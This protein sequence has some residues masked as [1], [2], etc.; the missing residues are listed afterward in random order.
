MDRP[1][2]PSS[3]HATGGSAFHR[4]PRTIHGIARPAVLLPEGEE[5]DDA[6][7]GDAN[8][9][10]G[11]QPD[12]GFPA[13]TPVAEMT[14]EQQVAYWRHYARQHEERANARGDYDAVKAKAAELDKIREQQMSEQEKAVKA[15]R[16]AALAE[17]RTG[18]LRD[19]NTSAV[20]AILDAS[21]QA[22][23]RTP[24][25][26]AAMLA[27]TNFESFVT[28]GAP[29]TGAILGHVDSIAGPVTGGG[30]NGTGTP[31][32]GQGNRGPHGKATGIEAGAAMYRERHG[33]K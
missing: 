29:D 12:R 15:A 7:T 14:T 11:G 18:A 33:T 28:D 16:E 8:G 25:Q 5:H 19:A 31:D 13:G 21:L 32:H 17:G 10:S 26:V 30:G 1:T 2:L 22:R 27:H 20:R 24:E 23:G 4:P 9:Q 3:C 6:G